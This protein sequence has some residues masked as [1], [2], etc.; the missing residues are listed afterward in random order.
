M[1]SPV[2]QGGGCNSRFGQIPLLTI[3]G[4]EFIHSLIDPKNPVYDTRGRGW[5]ACRYCITL[6]IQAISSRRHCFS[7][8]SRRASPLG[9][10]SRFMDCMQ[11][12]SPGFV[13][14]VTVKM[15]CTTVCLTRQDE[16]NRQHYVPPCMFLVHTTVTLY[17]PRPYCDLRSSTMYALVCSIPILWTLPSFEHPCM[18]LASRRLSPSVSILCCNLSPS[19]QGEKCPNPYRPSRAEVPDEPNERPELVTTADGKE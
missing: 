8:L 10:R 19:A 4:V 11:S 16:R 7:S 3:Y 14:L 15:R 13:G 9:P 6:Y 5:R 2:V 17:V 1:Q 12:S 18:R